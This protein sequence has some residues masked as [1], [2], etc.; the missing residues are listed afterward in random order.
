MGLAPGSSASLDVVCP[1]ARKLSYGHPEGM[2]V[3]VSDLT[4]V[5]LTRVN[6]TGSDVRVTTGRVLNPRAFPRQ[7]ASADWWQ[8]KSV[9]S[10]RWARKEHI[11]LLEMRSILLSFRWRIRHLAEVDCR[12][13]HLTD[14]Y[15]SMSIISKGRSSSDMI[16]HVMRQ[17][18]AT[19]FAFNLFP[20]LIHVESTENPTDTASRT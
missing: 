10:C 18:A 17:I 5:L 16:M 7:S 1:L 9:F 6:R 15:V 14:R 11:N 19:Q 8:W 3:T 20:I 2:G 4:R 13:I 12:F